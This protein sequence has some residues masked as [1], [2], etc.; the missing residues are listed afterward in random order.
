MSIDPCPALL[1]FLFAA[2][3]RRQHDCRR[4]KRHHEY[5]VPDQRQASVGKDVHGEDRR[6]PV[7]AGGA[8]GLPE[9]DPAGAQR[10]DHRRGALLHQPSGER[11]QNDRLDSVNHL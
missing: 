7:Y 9:A 5:S 1:F 6:L 4:G 11:L 2:D 10:R 3:D 8:G